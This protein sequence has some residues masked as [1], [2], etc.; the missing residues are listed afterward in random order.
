MVTITTA[1]R[2]PARRLGLIWTV[3]GRVAEVLIGCSFVVGTTC[4]LL[5]ALSAL[6]VLRRSLVGLT[7][8]RSQQVTRCTLF[9]RFISAF[10]ARWR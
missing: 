2:R 10:W 5:D 7:L 3:L 8:R 4:R 9:E 1:P 6:T